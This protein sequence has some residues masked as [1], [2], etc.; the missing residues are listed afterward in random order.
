MLCLTRSVNW[1]YSPNTEISCFL[2]CLPSAAHH[3]SQGCPLQEAAPAWSPNEEPL[4]SHQLC[5]G[6]LGT[7]HHSHSLQ[8]ASS[9]PRWVQD[10]AVWG[11]RGHRLVRARTGTQL[12]PARQ[13]YL[14]FALVSAF[15]FLNHRKGLSEAEIVS[16][17]GNV[18]EPARA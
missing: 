10:L 17:E 3:C 6:K 5:P 16:L 13:L 12:R 7:P 15:A 14:L 1:F 2:S 18:A 11:A 4:T 9:P 8:V